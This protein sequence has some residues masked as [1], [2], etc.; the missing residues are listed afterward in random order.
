[1]Q[2]VICKLHTTSADKLQYN[3]VRRRQQHQQHQVSLSHA[4]KRL[5][6]REYQA[7][8]D[9]VFSISETA[10]FASRMTLENR[11]DLAKDSL[12]EN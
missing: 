12:I 6:H 7:E 5:V 3:D 1:M 11:V 2:R 4:G 9:S 10:K 8:R